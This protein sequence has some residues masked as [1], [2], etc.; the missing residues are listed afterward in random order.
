M[1]QEALQ[2]KKCKQ[3]GWCC[4]FSFFSCEFFLTEPFFFVIRF[5]CQQFL[6]FANVFTPYVFRKHQEYEQQLISFYSKKM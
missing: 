6:Q 2:K 5:F 3:G 1:V 4:Y